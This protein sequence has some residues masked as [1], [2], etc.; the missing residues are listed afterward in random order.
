MKKVVLLFFYILCFSTNIFAQ[1]VG[2]WYWFLFQTEKILD[3]KKI[4]AQKRN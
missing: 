4:P 3:Y 2:V 1:G